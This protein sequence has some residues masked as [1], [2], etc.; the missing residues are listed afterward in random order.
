MRQHALGLQEPRALQQAAVLLTKESWPEV[1]TFKHLLPNTMTYALHMCLNLW[2]DNNLCWCPLAHPAN[3]SSK[4]THAVTWNNVSSFQCVRI[5]RTIHKC[6]CIALY[7]RACLLNTP[8]KVFA[9]TIASGL[10][11]L[12]NQYDFQARH[13]HGRVCSGCARYNILRICCNTCYLHGVSVVSSAGP[14]WYHTWHI[15][16]YMW[17]ILCGST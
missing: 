6:I 5:S 7:L 2:I 12:S 16:Q 4:S 17:S 10:L 3:K 15:V 11:P 14:T 8:F 9:A 13:P 1:I